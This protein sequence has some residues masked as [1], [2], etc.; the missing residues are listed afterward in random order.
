MPSKRMV[1]EQEVSEMSDE[2]ARLAAA[3][4]AEIAAL[5]N[6]KTAATDQ[7]A[8]VVAKRVA[9]ASEL[10]AAKAEIA[11]LKADLQV[12]SEAVDEWREGFAVSRRE[13]TALTE[14][15]DRAMKVVEAAR[16]FH[17]RTVEDAQVNGMICQTADLWGARWNLGT[18]FDTL[19]TPSSPSLPES[20]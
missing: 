6:A 18:M 7:L 16:V 15:R 19:D 2:M 14:Q 12:V 9:Q 1:P 10:K 11:A 20:P 13:I 3:K 17:K 5:T 4:D 8:D